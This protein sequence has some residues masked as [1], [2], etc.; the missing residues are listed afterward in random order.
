MPLRLHPDS[1]LLS[2]SRS[3]GLECCNM[4][5][6]YERLQ[7]QSLVF[8]CYREPVD[9]VLSSYEFAMEVAAR[10]AKKKPRRH[11]P[12]RVSH[13]PAGHTHPL[14]TIYKEIESCIDCV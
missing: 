7:S 13:N 5:I 8:L 1:V 2:H 11:D 12:S 9:R 14:S 4:P 3:N 6:E 10:A